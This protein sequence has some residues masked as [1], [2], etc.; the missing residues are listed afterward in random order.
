VQAGTATT[1]AA[2]EADLKQPLTTRG[3]LAW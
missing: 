1:G 3:E 2:R